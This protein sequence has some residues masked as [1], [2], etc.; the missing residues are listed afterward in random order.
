MQDRVRERVKG[1]EK[2]RG[3]RNKMRKESREGGSEGR[4][5]KGRIEGRRKEGGSE[6]RRKEGG[7]EGRR[8]GTVPIQP[9]LLQL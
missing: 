8:K 2:A 3:E 4:R 7:S 9:F 1:M 5:M 6:G